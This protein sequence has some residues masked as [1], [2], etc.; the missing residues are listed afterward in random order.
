MASTRS[1][2]AL[3]L[4]LALALVA[5]L[6][7]SLRASHAAAGD[8]DAISIVPS[9]GET[10]NGASAAG[11]DAVDAAN[12]R[13]AFVSDAS[14][15]IAGDTNGAADVFVFDRVARSVTRASVATG[16]GQANG[17]SSDAV[18][19]A[20]GRF[21]V[22]RS[23]ATNL[24]AGDTNG[25]EDVF[26]HD[27]STAATIRVSVA[28]GTGEQANGASIG[29]VASS[30][31]GDAI[32]F[33]SLASNLVSGDTNGFSDIFVWR[34]GGT[35]VRASVSS[36][37]AQA[38]AGSDSPALS[39]DGGL[40]AF[41]TAAA[42][43]PADT[44][45]PAAD[46]V[47]VRDVAAGVTERVSVSATGGQGNGAAAA[48]SM[49]ADGRSVA[50]TATSSNL[51]P[52]DDNAA[53][54]VFVRDRVLRDTSRASVASSGAGGNDASG[55]AT[56]SQDGRLVAFSSAASNLVAGDTNGASDVFVRDRI[57]ASTGRVSVA[58]GGAQAGGASFG[59]PA[60]SPDGSTL[61][62]TTA[63]SNLVPGDA[64]GATDVL[65]VALPFAAAPP[66]LRLASLSSS[67]GPANG[68]T[69]SVGLSGDGRFVAFESAASNL[70]PGD[71]NGVAD[72]FV[73]DSV[74]GSVERVSVAGGSA[75]A[76]GRS[77]EPSISADG[78]YVAFFSSASNLVPGD[79]NGPG[80]AGDD[81]FVRDRQ[82]ATTTRVSVNRFGLQVVGPSRAPQI[83]ADGRFV[84]FHSDALDL[85]GPDLNSATDVFRYDRVTGDVEMVSL[86]TGG[87]Q[88]N[89]ASTNPSVSEDGSV[90][91][92]QSAASNL[93]AGDTNGGT[94]VFA[95]TFAPRVTTRVS[96]ATGGVQGTGGNAVSGVVA[97]GG[98]HVAFHA[99][100]P[101][102]IAGDTNGVTDVFIHDRISAETSRVSVAFDGA[103]SNGVSTLQSRQQ[104]S[105]DGRFVAFESGATNLVAGDVN[106]ATDVF[107]RDVTAVATDRVSQS[108][109]GAGGSAASQMP[110]I[111]FDGRVVAFV[112]DAADLVA[113][114]A[115]GR[116]DAFTF[117]RAGEG[118]SIASV[119]SS[120]ATAAAA[121]SAGVAQRSVS[122]DGRMVVFVSAAA[123]LVPGDT[124][125]VADVFVRDRITGATRRV[126][127]SGAGAQA[128]L[129]SSEPAISSSGRF[130]VFTSLAPNLV[131]GDSNGA[132]DV[133]RA[134]L[135]TGDLRRAS[136]PPEGEL[137]GAS[138]RGVI[139]ADGRFVAFES[140][141]PNVPGDT[142]PAADVLVKD[143]SSG[144]LL[145]ASAGANAGASRPSIVDD[146]SVVAF[147][148]DASNLVSGD[149]NLA[150][151]AFAWIRATG[152]VSR[153]S[154]ATGGA[155]ADGPATGVAISR[156]GRFAAFASTATNLA[157]G[158][159]GV[160]LRD[161][162]LG[163]TELVS[164][165]EADGD[166]RDPA[167][168][169]EG[170]FVAFV[171]EA[172]N[173][174]PGDGNG[175]A[176]IFVRD[177]V[178]GGI[179]LASAGSFGQAAAGESRAP[180][181][182]AG[183]VVAVFDTDASNLAGY[184]R[185]GAADVVARALTFAP[186]P[187][188]TQIRNLGIAVDRTSIGAGIPSIPIGQVPAQRIV[189]M[190]DGAVRSAPIGSIP[191]GSIPLLGTV[192]SVPMGSIPIGSIPMGSIPMGSIGLDASPIGSIA[193]DQVLLSSLDADFA[194][195]LAGSSL[196]GLAPQTITLRRALADPVVGPRL[197]ALTIKGAGLS[198]TLLRGVQV[199]SVLLGGLTLDRIVLPGGLTVCQA[200]A[201]AG[202]SCAAKG[203]DESADTPIGLDLAS[204]P[205]GSIP[206]G[207]IPMG[208]IPMGSIPMG[209]IPMGSID[210]S[211]TPMGS[212]P[213]GS[214]PN[215]GA[216]VDCS[217]LDCA[218][219]TLGDAAKLVPSAIRD[220]AVLADL[221][222]ALDQITLGQLI[223]GLLA[224][225]DYPW[226][227]LPID[228]LQDDGNGP[229]LGYRVDYDFDCTPFS[230]PTTV[231]VAPPAG[232]RYVAGSSQFSFGASS[233][234]A[235]VDP[236]AVDGSLTWSALPSNPCAGI[237][238]EEQHVR[239]SYRMRPGF[240]L[241]QFSSNADVVVFRAADSAAGAAVHVVQNLEP[242]EDPV[243][244]PIVAP[245]TLVFGHIAAA[246]DIDLYR[247]AIPATPGTR[248]RFLLSHIEA[249]QDYDLTVFKPAVPSLQSSPIGSI[250]MG[251]IPI[252]DEG[253]DLS[254]TARPMQAETLR[255]S[256]IGS[257]PMGS[258]PI[259]SISQNRGDADEAALIVTAGEAGHFTV[260]VAGFNGSHGN[261]AYVLR[262]QSSA[263]VP[264]PPC[265]PRAFAFDADPYAGADETATAGTL[266]ASITPDRRALFLVARNRI[267]DL[268][269]PGQ[270]TDLM[271][272]L[273][274][275][276][277]RADVAG[278]VL[279]VDAD[280]GVRDA[281]MAWDAAPCSIERAN[282]VVRAVNDVVTRYRATVPG[283]RYV[284][285][286]GADEALPMARVADTVTLSNETDYASSLAF[287]TAGL[288]KANATYAAAA[289]G[290]ILTD[291]AYGTLTA[292]PWLDRHLYLPDLSVARLVETPAEIR[293]QIGQYIA[294]GG[295]LS[296]QTALTSGYD[297]LS[298]G[299]TAIASGIDD[300][301]S[302][303]NTTERLIND[304]WDKDDL[305]SRIVRDVISANAHYDHYRAQP[306]VAATA[307]DLVST[308]DG[309]F[310]VD[311]VLG[312][313]LADRVSFTIGCHS[314]LNVADSLIANASADQRTLL[315]D[316]AQTYAQVKAA[317]YIANTGFGYGDTEA[318]AL[319]ERLMS[320]FAKRLGDGWTTIGEKL[321]AAKHAYFATAGL[322]GVYD[323]KALIEATMYGLPFW[324]LGPDEPAPG[325]VAPPSTTTDPLTGLTVAS[326]SMTP[327]TTRVDTPRGS[328]WRGPSGVHMMH[329]RPLQPLA[330]RDVTVAGLLP[331]GVIV[332]ALQTQDVPGVD[333]VLGNP[334]IARAANEPERPAVDIVYPANLVTLA[335][336]KPFGSERA[337]LGVIAGQFRGNAPFDGRGT[338]RLVTSITVE[339]AYSSSPVFVP[340]H[341]AQAAVVDAPGGVQVV[342]DVR[343]VGG[344]GVSRVAMLVRHT[345]DGS[346]EFVEAVNLP[347][348]S[349]WLAS[350]AT[351]SA[352][353]QVDVAIMG[354]DVSGN[355]GWGTKKGELHRTGDG[356]IRPVIT[357]LSPPA[358]AVYARGQDVRADYGC[359]DPAGV[360]SC[361][362]TVPRG[363]PIDTATSGTKSF[364]VTMVNAQSETS[365]RT[366]T[367]VVGFAFSG[368]HAPVT[369]YPG[370]T[371]AT[372]G[373]T[374]PIK[375]TIK[376][377]N[378]NYVR[379]PSTA[380]S[381]RSQT[382]SCANRPSGIAED[383][384]TPG[385]IVAVYN[386]GGEH[387]Q[388]DWR[389]DAAW[390]NT[391]RRV[392]LTLSDGSKHFFDV[393]LK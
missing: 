141:A 121:Q 163:T 99:S 43:V 92:F 181:I 392:F 165:A 390:K 385:P 125:G 208:S 161:R 44:Q 66:A 155:Q 283:L 156:T 204:A 374:L 353:D 323:E 286:V 79:S 147:V 9:T 288:T 194:A 377:G 389:T 104:I 236:V 206:M 362:G 22:F 356:S 257:I 271:A 106:A 19:S 56:I 305:L 229:Q 175:V 64:N 144:D 332:K 232:F 4:A 361:T 293:G 268:Y 1:R 58:A 69:T 57:L 280:A 146:G 198:D 116:R 29:P 197:R 31:T 73:R 223:V 35:I 13:V 34:S 101:N 306:A 172:T 203:V 371:A 8:T 357:I 382:I 152:A 245:D 222:A 65:A 274:T 260:A 278:S 359:Y 3:A 212:I 16:G 126:S 373:S 292:T 297:F 21:V 54:D 326:I 387:F 154:L 349:I 134:D 365:S 76:D 90:V 378:G 224:R 28:G 273:G 179:R 308:G 47:Y 211:S 40:V 128:T 226:E 14:N 158:R 132:A 123:G 120:N 343:D 363:A 112:S 384:S 187:V 75:Q 368:F 303:G 23:A 315:R 320:E 148:S 372:A 190:L 213:I 196:E 256:P 241:G 369:N 313:Q 310:G 233:P 217:R 367:Y 298:D 117:D 195:L 214:I 376:D 201:Q 379:D 170:R 215:A 164:G 12:R 95:R 130:V 264:L 346:W 89:G 177:T 299:A 366:V 249:G 174:V 98:R 71:T 328:F 77:G 309:V 227:R 50:F 78:R 262:V 267:A 162:T 242:S 30:G 191:I 355:V 255:D 100:Y 235:A 45:S 113:S 183:G 296:P 61:A 325:P 167:I 131:A 27:L 263:P 18:L 307:S 189:T 248:V 185:N 209:S 285:L 246:D 330:T 10:A 340:P 345:A 218:T 193:L 335:R 137:A 81:V 302:A 324:K 109:A 72:V 160:F 358:G 347:G 42:L 351:Q 173:L 344:G 133:F 143:V 103:Q 322:Y 82:A 342:A 83:S 244:A 250:P 118:A 7:T 178:L 36:S 46:D 350:V 102:L 329:H 53:P 171:G 254:G 240:T 234:Q 2:A 111:S 157:P 364:T 269:G 317:V 207:S 200:L 228:G 26:R 119:S 97:A 243:T 182:A 74:T 87:A 352:A 238:G 259:G 252:E 84:V 180:S 231:T 300:V 80:L 166:S 52:D 216:I 110:A 94:D 88:G 272:S 304:G 388:Y 253:A 24:V 176:D 149:T 55:P 295:R 312:S 124:N 93:A 301:L 168:S 393:S 331:H 334:T 186:A 239:L 279:A 142:N 281:L 289:L 20:N 39:L 188:T 107:V 348:T 140:S 91:A 202:Y 105:A 381:L 62:Y 169:S 108:A 339:V 37:G 135:L 251:S 32:A 153:I 5:P 205:M 311:P 136:L 247:V 321:V 316:W 86:S 237:D 230:P 159:P 294:A 67:S 225:T 319:S 11:R 150:A 282:A 360:V 15:L 291:D 391:C 199:A 139:S 354:Q 275:L 68:D 151:D 25:S 270:A 49:S 220:G 386:L 129:G 85:T 33:S 184:D 327:P 17:P 145:I 114:D 70:V 383:V 338:Q 192:G 380:K 337:T 51:V 290:Q 59:A 314:G 265:P 38:T 287:T 375:W 96:V 341:I 41:R 115:N 60:I 219:A 284:V 48:P 277:A 210:I 138:G 318:V 276:A 336:S 266:P 63:A 370:I 127:V 333:P 6:A 261:H 258:I 221:G 122:N